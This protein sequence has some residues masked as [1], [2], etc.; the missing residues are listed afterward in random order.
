[1]PAAP[2]TVQRRCRAGYPRS[3]IRATF[4]KVML[5]TVPDEEFVAYVPERTFFRDPFNV[6]DVVLAT[7]PAGRARVLA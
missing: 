6:G 5:D 2:T 7:W 4:V 3:N 1:M